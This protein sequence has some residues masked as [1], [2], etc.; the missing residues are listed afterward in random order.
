MKHSNLIVLLAVS[1]LVTACGWDDGHDF[2][3]GVWSDDGE[4]IAAVR[5]TFEYKDTVTHQKRRN[6]TVQVYMND[7]AT[8][9]PLTVLSPE[10]EGRATAL[11]YM[12][13]AGYI[14]LGREGEAQETTDGSEEALVAYDLIDMN[15]T[16]TSLGSGVY[17]TMLSCD[18][19]QSS[20]SLNDNLRVIPSPDGSILAKFISSTTCTSR[21]ESLTFLDAMSLSVIAGPFDVEVGPPNLAFPSSPWAPRELAWTVDNTFMI[22]NWGGGAPVDFMYAQIFSVNA[23]PETN[24][25][26]KMSCFWPAT[27]SSF[28]GDTGTYINLSNDGDISL[29]QPI[30]SSTTLYFGCD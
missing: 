23:E 30:D 1:L 27:T 21:T 2:E 16:T 3:F 28:E 12:R 11:Y 24:V 19:G 18:G 15:G 17:T 8:G 14:V 22:A 6:Y 9:S 26:Q 25:L 7:N 4:A 13:D 5:H 10:L 20:S 29:E